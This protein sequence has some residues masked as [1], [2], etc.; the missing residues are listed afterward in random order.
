MKILIALVVL[1]SVGSSELFAQNLPSY[2]ED[3]N[4]YQQKLQDIGPVVA[5]GASGSSGLMATPFPLLVASQ[6]CL[7]KGSGYESRYSIFFFGSKISF[8]KKMF[9]EKRPKI[10][11]AIDHLHHS[12]KGKRF[13]VYPVSPSWTE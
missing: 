2:C 10:V 12:S 3:N 5:V 13:N 6:M 4:N 7:K 1:I 9:I 11:V 8:L